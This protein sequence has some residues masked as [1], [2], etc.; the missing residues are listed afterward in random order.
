M[1]K[2]IMIV[3][4]VL[5]I[6]SII[7]AVAYFFFRE[8]SLS[9]IKQGFTKYMV[10]AK[11]STKLVVVETKEFFSFPYT[12]K[13]IVGSIGVSTVEVSTWAHIMYY[14]D[15]E[16]QNAWSIEK[17]DKTLI[18]STPAIKVL[19]PSIMT[20]QIKC[21]I[22]DSSI[23]VDEQK[24]IE[25]AKKELTKRVA[26]QAGDPESI[27]KVKN[28]ARDSLNKFFSGFLKKLNYKF[29]NIEIHIKD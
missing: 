13:A 24:I 23:F 27:Q 6:I 2:I 1:K 17:R 9:V 16:D 26:Q 3:V 22:K 15:F 4:S 28:Q 18:L 11:G 8:P 19:P 29:D 25:E 21:E 7:L 20:D 10:E 12:T 5:V 14:I